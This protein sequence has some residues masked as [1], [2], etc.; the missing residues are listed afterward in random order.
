[1]NRKTV[2]LCLVLLIGNSFHN[3]AQQS[4]D[5]LKAIWKNEALKDTIRF[6]ALNKYYELT[7]QQFPDSALIAASYHFDL[8][9]AKRNP[10]EMFSALKYRGN[11]LR[12]QQK[13]KEAMSAYLSA[14]SIAEKLGDSLLLAAIN[15]NIGNVHVYQKD[16]VLATRRF[17]VAL[18]IYE[19]LGKV[20]GERRMFTNL[21][22]I[23]LIIQNYE[24][25]LEYYSKV[26][27][28]LRLSNINDRSTAII[29]MN[30]GWANYEM[31]RLDTARDYYLKALEIFGREKT[32]FF[33]AECYSFL[34][35]VLHEMKENPAAL[36]Y[37]IKSREL[38]R[39]L[40]A[41]QGVLSATIT[42]AQIYYDKNPDQ[43][44]K[45][46]EPLTEEVIAQSDN[47]IKKKH[48]Q[49]LYK[50]YKQLNR[51]N[52][53]LAMYELYSTYNDSVFLEKNNFKIIQE[54]YKRD[55]EIQAA[56]IE[57]NNQKEREILKTR[58]FRNIIII[59][60]I[61]LLVVG[62][63]VFLI[64]SNNAKSKMKRLEL[65]NEIEKI[66]RIENNALAIGSEALPLDRNRIE[67]F[68][69][70]KINE[71][72][73]KVLNILLADPSISNKE[74][75]DRAFMSVDGIGSSLRRMY[76]YF[77][78]KET[79]YKKI[80][81]IIIAMNVSKGQNIDT[82]DPLKKSE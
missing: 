17:S 2:F 9:N 13:Y 77:E 38:N 4:I 68:I 48:F 79:K 44:L 15:G 36:E 23:F 59:I 67:A 65:L 80:A 37:A 66:K 64:I 47:L 70:R 6:G 60:F 43:A 46:A 22:S 42:E 8:A 25:A 55:Y 10:G 53:A 52:E 20:D 75:A 5:S 39:Q 40:G 45:I 30:M 28:S 62:V 12:L 81:L 11:I 14:E 33:V 27:Q 21:G 56:Q 3:Y 35:L 76:E 78:V 82:K 24:L 63:L 16:Y 51:P 73:W 18:R 49:L 34:A 58:Q 26:L 72:D 1:M 71:T 29:Y 61:S 32:M 57:L 74:I 69:K 54:A 19:G 50:C 7:N 41:R 31:G